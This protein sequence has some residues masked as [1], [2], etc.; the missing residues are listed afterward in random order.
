MISSLC[1]R[2]TFAP[3]P[4]RLDHHHS[5][6]AYRLICCSLRCLS[7]VEE[8]RFKNQL[9]F[10]LISFCIHNIEVPSFNLA[11]ILAYFFNFLCKHKQK[12]DVQKNARQK[13]REKEGERVEQQQIR[14]KC[15][16]NAMRPIDMPRQLRCWASAAARLCT[17]HQ[18]I[19]LDLISL[20]ISLLLFFTYRLW[21]TME[22]KRTGQRTH[23]GLATLSIVCNFFPV[24]YS[25][26]V[27][28]VVAL[29]YVLLSIWLC[30]SFMC[31]I[32]SFHRFWPLFRAHFFYTRL[33]FIALPFASI[34]FLFFLVLHLISHAVFV[35]FTFF[36]PA[37][38]FFSLKTKFWWIVVHI[39]MNNVCSKNGCGW[40]KGKITPDQPTSH[41][42]NRNRQTSI[43]TDTWGG[44]MKYTYTIGRGEEFLPTSEKRTCQLIYNSVS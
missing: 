41:R 7:M 26:L 4:C 32:S 8:I 33:C 44:K 5:I 31:H 19:P 9:Q 36:T 15:V 1:E 6:D 14:M 10:T 11:L 35:M 43:P 2:R 28:V 34:W 29:F 27:V 3:K 38:C 40:K 12:R 37:H 23:T 22:E 18:G 30:V 39:F 21:F 16:S 25:V 20:R 24:A 17:K 42:T 13:Y